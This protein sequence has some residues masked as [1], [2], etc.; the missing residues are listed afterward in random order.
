[1]VGV[2]KSLR[3]DHVLH[4]ES[5]IDQVAVT[6]D[7]DVLEVAQQRLAVVPRRLIRL[8]HHV[9]AI[10]RR[11]RDGRD[12]LDVQACG[13]G[14]EFVANP[15]E[16]LLIPVDEIHLVD[17]EHHMLHTEQ[18]R[19]K[20]M[21]AGLLEQ[22]V[23]GIDEHDHQLGGRGS[24]HHVAGVLDVARRVSDDEF[25]LGRGEVAVGHVDG[26]ALFALRTQ[27]VGHQRE[28]G[29]VVTAL[30]R[31]PF[32]GRELVL[33]DGLRVVEQPP[34]QGGFA[35]VD[36]AGGSDPQQCAHQK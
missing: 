8:G 23:A 33:H 4:R 24:G 6:G 35:V 11:H 21:P 27:P 26:D 31:G 13:E 32:H 34:D 16:P 25:P 19:Q 36:R 7:V 22:T 28:V 20:G 29:V 14:V 1:M 5:D 9:V 12:I 15:V 17:G 10:E 2:L 30:P 18:R 3:T